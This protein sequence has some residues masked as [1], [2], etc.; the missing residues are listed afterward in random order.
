MRWFFIWLIILPLHLYSQSDLE[1]SIDGIKG[2]D[3][4]TITQDNL[5][6]ALEYINS[7][8]AG[9]A[10]IACYYHCIGIFFYKEEDYVKAINFH[11]EALKL[12]IESHKEFVWKSYFMVGLAY[13]RLE[14]FQTSQRL[15]QTAYD[16]S[17]KKRPL[18]SINIFRMMAEN[19]IEI[20][21]FQQSGQYAIQATKINGGDS[22]KG[23]A[24]N[25]L[26]FV[27]GWEG[28]DSL[29]LEKAIKN[30]DIA[31]YFY[32]QADAE[33]ARIARALNNKAIALGRLGRYNEAIKIY[34]LALD[35]YDEDSEAYAEVL[36]NIGHDLGKQGAYVEAI[37]ILNQSL[38]HIRVYYENTS[39]QYTYAAD[40]ENLAE[41]YE[42]LNNID[43][44]LEHYQLALI[45]LTDNFRNQDINTNP[46]VKDNHYIYNKPDLIRV[47]D[48]KAQ[49]ALKAKKIDLAHDTYQELDNW[50][51]E[52]YKDLS[53]KT[54]KL[55]WIAR[56]HTIYGN[57][58]DVALMQGKQEKAFEYAEKAH[59]VL[60]WQ[61][62]SQ[63]AARNL[64]SEEDKE[65]MDNLTAKI[66]QAD[67]Q[68]RNGD[69]K[70]QALRTLEREREALE[71]IFDE[72]H[73][74]YAQRKYQPEATTVSDI[75]SDI[76]DDHTAFIEYYQTD[77]TLYI[78]TITKN[79]LEITQES[80][81]GLTDNISNF[82]N[83]ISGKPDMKEQSVS[84][85]S[86]I[87]VT[88]R[89]GTNISLQKMDI[90]SY[91]ALAHKLYKQLIPS[92]IHSN[93]NIKRLVI[94]PDREIG[95]LPFAALTTQA[96]SGQLNKNT[97]FLVK[98]Y[99]TN[100]LYSTGSY[101]QLQQ[102][103][104]DQ[105]Y[106]FAGIAP[107]EYT[108]GNWQKLPNSEEE[109]N[110]IKTLH[111]QWNRDILMREKATKAEFERIVKEGYR[112]IQIS[113]HAIF[114][115]NK[116]RIIFYDSALTQDEIDQLEINTHRLILSACETGVGIQNQGE[117]I[118]S[119]GWNFA[120]KGVPS[121]T[122]S[123][124]SVSDNSTK[125]I[126]ID[127]H[128][129]LNDGIP[130]D[131]ALQNAQQYYLENTISDTQTNPRYWAAFFHTGN[132]K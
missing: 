118:L 33:S 11:E 103:K 79:G 15:I 30:T 68:Y 25:T 2:C 63:Q 121:I 77:E 41:N 113:T 104:A 24:Y 116:G 70:I 50:I 58:I 23:S 119:L 10:F 115:E 114:D 90:E 117:G 18:D 51:T 34:E 97:P 98:K 44:A 106:C 120:Y 94:V 105:K 65:K 52:F 91:H 27:L 19:L 78:F 4:D 109:L 31:I 45:N 81:D 126:M 112:T 61:S 84:N 129:N 102:K 66:R 67:Q 37:E 101:L 76:I 64:L 53:T 86:D 99:T 75:Q 56:A 111:W 62:L 39:F 125:D 21:E 36:N 60:L 20:G 74:D 46:T 28:Q 35:K 82:V 73:P 13:K 131:K 80:A 47:L 72:Q 26:A 9:N 12:R 122:M 132:V 124:W 85:E 71:K 107:L 127:Y 22:R 16:M 88:L 40:Y 6:I 93:D 14:M 59:A 42:A 55:T 87:P 43:K 89:S 8:P 57:A 7:K 100:Y 128:K 1:I 110:K 17:G 92:A 83:N 96:T 38:Q 3:C 95:M 29:N 32:E 48:L 5:K 49:A 69:I 108:H 54:S 130:A 123:H